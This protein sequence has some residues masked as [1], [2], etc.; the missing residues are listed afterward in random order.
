MDYFENELSRI[1]KSLVE[2][3]ISN[4]CS[5]D[6]TTELLNTLK[7]NY[8]RIVNHPKNLGAQENFSWCIDDAKG[9]YFWL[10]GDDDYLRVGLLEKL[11]KLLQDND[12]S[13]IYLP[14][15]RIVESTHTIEYKAKELIIEKDVKTSVSKKKLISLLVE[16]NSELTFQTS[17]IC[18]HKIAKDCDSIISKWDYDA[19]S[20]SHTKLKAIMAMQKGESYFFSD[21]CILKGD[22]ILWKDKRVSFLVIGNNK[23][24]DLYLSNFGFSKSECKKIKR[25]QNA[26]IYLEGL[27]H[28]ELLGALKKE[29]FPGLEPMI[30]P[31]MVYLAARKILRVCGL[32]NNYVKRDIKKSEFMFQ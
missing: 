4:D 27:L 28:H 18:K 7:C 9:E 3:V 17:L 13:F 2:V 21:V 19:Q 16:N 31:I 14:Y 12:I 5:N 23:L 24:C 29:G 8:V 15:R 20:A 25:Y 22:E 10:P 32:S 1:D 11:V 26:R 30:A 6:G